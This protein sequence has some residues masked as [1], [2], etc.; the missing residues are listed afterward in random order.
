MLSTRSASA[1]PRYTDSQTESHRRHDH[2]PDVYS[3]DNLEIISAFQDSSFDLISIDQRQITRSA[4]GYPRGDRS[5]RWLVIHGLM[6]FA[7]SLAFLIAASHFAVAHAQTLPA[8]AVVGPSRSIPPYFYGMTLDSTIYYQNLWGSPSTPTAY[9][10]FP[11]LMKGFQFETVRYPGGLESQCWSWS[12]GTFIP[13]TP[14]QGQCQGFPGG[15]GWFDLNVLTQALDTTAASPLFN[16]NVISASFD[17][18]TDPN[19]QM[20]LLT[21]AQASGI[22]VEL[23]ELGNEVYWNYASYTAPFP[24]P[25]AYANQAS[26][27]AADIRGVFPGAQVAAVAATIPPHA[28]AQA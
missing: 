25:Q 4:G 10:P 13:N 16:L 11:T 1:H 9:P 21:Q 5:R 15:T 18:P 14:A 20:A 8:P 22:T 24:T 27:W 23:I 28:Q 26:L 7:R 12:T 2:V 6:T 19:N 3:G 17:T